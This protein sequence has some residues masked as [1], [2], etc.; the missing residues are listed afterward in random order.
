MPAKGITS[1]TPGRCNT[2]VFPPDGVKPW[3]QTMIVPEA[4]MLLPPSG[5]VA[6]V[7]TGAV[8][9]GHDARYV[10][11]LPVAVTMTACGE[12]TTVVKAWPLSEMTKRSTMG[13]DP[14]LF[15]VNVPLQSGRSEERRVGKEC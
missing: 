4:E 15:T 9:A 3:P 2:R 10:I 8:F 11:F 13:G 1:E 5:S 6:A 14:G 12:T 7:N